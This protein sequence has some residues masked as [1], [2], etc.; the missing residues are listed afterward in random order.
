MIFCST[1][2]SDPKARQCA[3]QLR[4]FTLIELLVVISIITLLISIL[5][6]A[7]SSARQ[8]ARNVK[9][10]SSLHQMAIAVNAYRVD[11]KSWYPVN[12]LWQENI[13]SGTIYQPFGA[14]RIYHYIYQVGPYLGLDNPNEY[15]IHTQAS[16]SP[17]QCPNNGWEGYNGSGG[18]AYIGQFVHF[19]GGISTGQNYI[20][21]VQY[22]H[23]YWK[24]RE[25]LGYDMRPKQI[26]PRQPSVQILN[27]EIAGGAGRPGDMGLIDDV[28]YWHPSQS[29][30]TLIADGHVTSF[31]QGQFDQSGLK[32]LWPQ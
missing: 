27:L 5:L 6:P 13:S 19:K 23:S 31:Q 20:A 1:S 10:K 15:T 12:H 8:A 29:T 30:N 28:K 11:S 4:A 9:C 3:R 32:I 16:K 25:P 2:A 24:T 18:L 17:F 14:G 22:G 21:P 7:L 26:D